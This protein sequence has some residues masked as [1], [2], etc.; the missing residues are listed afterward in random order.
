MGADGDVAIDFHGRVSFPAARQLIKRLEDVSPMFIEEPVVPENS[1]L[2]ADLVAHTHLP[3][4]TGERLYSR[5]EFLPV[6]HWPTPTAPCW[7]RTARSARSPWRPACR[8]ASPPATTSSRS[9]AWASTTTGTLTCLT[10][11]STSRC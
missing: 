8:S 11:S 9:R 6:L 5:Q 4:A 3:I 7:H 2:Y 10:W 1:H